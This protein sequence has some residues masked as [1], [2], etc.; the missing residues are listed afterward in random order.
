[1]VSASTGYNFTSG[2]S[3]SGPSGLPYTG[4]AGAGGTCTY[5]ISGTLVSSN[6]TVQVEQQS[7]VP[8]GLTYNSTFVGS[9]VTR[10]ISTTN[11]QTNPLSPSNFA[12][13]NGQIIVTVTR[14]APS[15]VSQDA[16]QIQFIKNSS[17]QSTQS[18]SLGQSISKTY[19]FTGV[20]SGDALKIL[21]IEG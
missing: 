9:A 8:A 13:G 16:G 10:Q 3:V 11:T 7:G 20:T 21:I 2:P 1:V 5:T 18:F 4:I 15:S 14:T 6:C 17:A 19:T 12:V